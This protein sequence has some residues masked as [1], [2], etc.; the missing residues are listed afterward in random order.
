MSSYLFKE[1]NI[2]FISFYLNNLTV[3]IIKFYVYLV[4]LLFVQT[5]IYIYFLAKFF[6]KETGFLRAIK[7]N[8]GKLRILQS[9]N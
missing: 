9:R 2:L 4:F 7:I 6:V 8:Q 3:L 5:V 1:V